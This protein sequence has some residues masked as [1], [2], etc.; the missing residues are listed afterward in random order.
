SGASASTGT[1]TG[2]P[3]SVGLSSGG[4]FGET[5]DNTTT[6]ISDITQGSTGTV[7]SSLQLSRT[8]SLTAN[9]A[10]I[11][12]KGDTCANPSPQ[13][14]SGG[15]TVAG[16]SHIAP[17]TDP[18]AIQPFWNDTFVFVVHPQFA[19]YALQSGQS[20]YVWTGAV[21]STA[22]ASVAQLAACE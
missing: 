10:A 7:A 4:D 11:P 3:P 12:G 15:S 2:G 21:P 18:I 1:P 14:P 20:R 19:A 13:C 16:C 6:T 17:T 22:S 5:W 8:Y 9:Q